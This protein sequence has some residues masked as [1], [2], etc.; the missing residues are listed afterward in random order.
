[1]LWLWDLRKWRW[2][3]FLL[4]FA[5]SL[6]IVQYSLSFPITELESETFMCFQ[7]MDRTNPM[8]KHL[9]SMIEERGMTEAPLTPQMFGNAGREH[10]EKYGKVAVNQTAASESMLII[11]KFKLVFIFALYH[12]L[13]TLSGTTAEHF[14][15]IGYKNHKHSV[16]NP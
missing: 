8:D 4:R 1:M 12:C 2:D 9:E 15:K 3:R 7:Y 11:V 6:V 5:L 14:A 16:N 13:I 10:M